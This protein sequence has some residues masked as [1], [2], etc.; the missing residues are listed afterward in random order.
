MPRTSDA[1][2]LL[3]CFVAHSSTLMNVLVRGS[4]LPKLRGAGATRRSED[5]ASSIATAAMRL[6]SR[7]SIALKWGPLQRRP[8][9]EANRWQ[10]CLWERVW[11][12]PSR[13]L[14]SLEPS[15]TDTGGTAA[16]LRCTRPSERLPFSWQA[17]RRTAQK[18]KR[19][20]E[21]CALL[22]SDLQNPDL[23]AQ[24]LQDPDLTSPGFADSRKTQ[25]YDCERIIEPARM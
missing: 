2:A 8:R 4:T 15:R 1:R 24:H 17:L 13:S 7:G 12:S 20:G 23:F 10:G 22:S 14:C 5:V 11:V 21:Q 19:R 25:F 18:L 9:E 16:G 3:L 6:H